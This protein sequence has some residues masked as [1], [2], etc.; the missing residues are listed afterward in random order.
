MLEY[1]NNIPNSCIRS[2]K[3][4]LIQRTREPKQYVNYEGTAL[5]NLCKIL[6]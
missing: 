3:S 2:F 5:F 4:S 1:F 6:S